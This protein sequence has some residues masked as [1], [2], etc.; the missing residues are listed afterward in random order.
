MNLKKFLRKH[1]GVINI[2]QLEKKAGLPLNKL[3]NAIGKENRDF[4][5]IETKKVRK[6]LDN[7]MSDLT[8]IQYLF[9][10]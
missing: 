2:S 5:F 3:A 10:E 9:D 1:K 8:G 4:G 6:V 7:M